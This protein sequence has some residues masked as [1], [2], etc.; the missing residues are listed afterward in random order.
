MPTLNLGH[1]KGDTGAAAELQATATHIQWR[2]VGGTTWT[3]LIA[4]A[5]IT[6][7]DAAVTATNIAA[8]IAAAAA[9]SPPIDAD[10]ISL[11][12]SAAAGAL[13]R[14]S[15]GGLWTWIKAKLGGTDAVS[16]GGA[17]AFTSRPTSADASSPAASSLIT[18]S[19]AND[20]F[21]I[22]AKRYLFPLSSH[23]ATSGS[24]GAGTNDN[25]G[26]SLTGGTTA[27]AWQ[28]GGISRTLLRNSG[29][30]GANGQA[31]VP[32]AIALRGFLYIESSAN[33]EARFCMGQNYAA[34][35]PAIGSP[36]LTTVG[37]GCRI[38]YSV[39]NARHEVVIFVHDG[40]SY[41]ESA[42]AALGPFTEA[43]SSFSI[44][45]SHN[46]AG[47]V[48]LFAAANSLADVSPT[49]LLTRTNGPSSGTYSNAFFSAITR[50]GPT[51]PS[52]QIQL[53]TLTHIVAY[54]H[55]P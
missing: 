46:G 37:F 21:S 25:N 50:N 8:A 41:N 33:S 3:N 10:E 20:L 55:L 30:S 54:Q 38:Y 23:F 4:L 39:A 48:K 42:A 43:D 17:W 16:V 7:A 15:F 27:S 45:L 31:N 19:D 12:D 36:A 35:P 26:C 34:A 44:V 24:G 22:G 29:A 28:G 6:G 40:T 14:L 1:V 49:A 9:K 47:M 52:A 5:D 53:K 32:F 2:P 51:P 18:R 11:L 13:K